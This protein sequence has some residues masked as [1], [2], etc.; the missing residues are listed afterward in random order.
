MHAEAVQVRGAEITIRPLSRGDTAT[1]QAV[2]DRLSPE[3]R[4]ARFGGAKNCLSPAELERFA[5]LDARHDVLVASDGEAAIGIARLVRDPDDPHVADVAFAVA[6]EWQARG[7]GSALVER[8][9]ANARA[10]GITHLRATMSGENRA[11]LALMR[12]ATTI[13]RTRERRGELEVVGRAA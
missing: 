12:H 8:L 11:S 1:I 4:Y 7:V 2:F 6:D 3:S 9:A 5:R 10:A 13:E